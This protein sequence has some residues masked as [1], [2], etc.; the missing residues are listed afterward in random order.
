MNFKDEI[1]LKQ[2]SFIRFLCTLLIINFIACMN[3]S[4]MPNVNAEAETILV[5]NNLTNQLIESNRLAMANRVPVA[6]VRERAKARLAAML[7]QIDQHANALVK[8]LLPNGVTATLLPIAK[9]YLES[10]VQNIEGSFIAIGA[11]SDNS[12]TTQFLLKTDAD[13]TYILHFTQDMQKLP[14]TGSRVTITSAVLIPALHGND[15]L[16]VLG[17]AKKPGMVQATIIPPYPTTGIFKTLAILVNFQDAPTNQPWTPDSV[18]QTLLND[19]SG[20]FYENSSHLTTLTVDTAGWFTTTVNSTD[21]CDNVTN[22]LLTSAETMAKAAGKDFAQYDRVMVLFP[23]MSNCRWVG[24]GY[25]GGGKTWGIT[26]INGTPTQQ[27]MAHELGHNFGLYHSHSQ[28]CS[29][30]PISGTCTTSDYGDSADTMGNKTASHFGAAQKESLGWLDNPGLPAITTVTNSGTYKIEPYE[31]FTNGVKAIRI[32]V[33]NPPTATSEY[34]YIEYRQLLGYDKVLSSGNLT[35]GVLIRTGLRGGTSNSSYLLNMVAS[36]ASFFNAA[37]TPGNTFTDTT[38]GHTGVNV[39]LNSA[40]TS[41]ATVSVNFGTSPGCTRANPTFTVSP[42]TTPWVAPGQ[43]AAYTLT[44][45]NNDSS[46]CANSTFNLGATS[47]AGVT[48]I[49]P[50]MTGSIAP[51]ASGTVNLIIQSTPTTPTGI[52]SINMTAVNG[53]NPSSSATLTASL[54]VQ[55]ACVRTNPTLTMSPQSQTGPAGSNVSYAISIK[56]NDSTTCAASTF[57]LTSII[58]TGLTGTLNTQSVNLAP[59]ASGSANLQVASQATTPAASYTASVQAV[60]STAPTFTATASSSYVVTVPCT[61]VAPTIIISPSTQNTADLNP[62][63]YTVKITNNNSSSCGYGLFKFSANVDDWYLKTFME[64][65]NILVLPGQTG[66]SLLTVTPTVGLKAGSHVISVVGAGDGGTSTTATANL[67]YSI[68]PPCVHA[69]PTV[70]VTPA[71]QTGPAGNSVAYVYSVKNND[72]ATCLASPFAMNAV[73]PS[74][75]TGTFNSS[76]LSIA[77]QG[78]ANSTLT[79]ASQTSTPANT[80]SIGANAVNTTSSSST[81]SASASYVVTQ[82]QQLDLTLTTD[83]SIY[84]RST[85]TYNANLYA[86]T[87]LSGVR[88]SNVPLVGTLKY[89]DGTSQ[90]ITTDSSWSGQRWFGEAINMSSQVGTYVFS[91]TATYQGKTVSA[92]LSFIVQ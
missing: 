49:Y 9:P 69:N 48:A 80:Y 22:T 60:N 12:S 54:G 37:L 88:V 33:V 53:V 63:N 28:T 2:T 20:F 87:T 79:V 44:L 32:P 7:E 75:F 56:N 65:Y 52:Y 55:P 73:L 85:T 24:L 78:S 81:G 10:N 58:P 38:A 39:T 16:I 25:I 19:V 57:N 67:V 86:T 66:T 18:K 40:D 13:K 91:S 31:S 6:L 23:R 77:P 47:V 45:K 4:A 51:G 92:S 11:T 42:S 8:S 72:S 50:S 36:D 74:G 15:N 61:Y 68:T 35:K 5:L 34:Y 46:A 30:G 64:P 71:T 84:Q 41:G 83:K 29:D 3:A 90:S 82:A 62:V 59:G 27:V 26:W 21:S 76:M 89:P 43:S 1:M 17:D 70:T 14:V